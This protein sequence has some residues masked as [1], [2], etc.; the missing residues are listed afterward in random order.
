MTEVYA[1]PKRNGRA[2]A[3]DLTPTADEIFAGRPISGDRFARLDDVTAPIRALASDA[4]PEYV[5]SVLLAARESLA[6]ADPLTRQTVR[7]VALDALKGR[8]LGAMI[9]A[10][11]ARAPR[12]TTATARERYA[13]GSP[14]RLTEAGSAERFAEQH[15]DQVRFDHTRK[16]WLLWRGHRWAPDADAAIHRLALAFVRGWQREVLDLPGEKESAMKFLLRLERRDALA[17]MIGLAAS[18]KPLADDGRDW[19]ADPDLLGVPN[20]V[21]D[22]RSGELRDG[23]PEDRITMQAAVA[24]DPAATCPRWEQFVAEI[25]PDLD[26]ANFIH[27]AIGYALTG[28]TSEQI[29]LFLL[30]RGANGK[31]TLQDVL[32]RMLGDYGHAL[33][34]SV[35]EE[36]RAGSPSNELAALAGRRLVISSE[37]SEGRRL[38]AGRV[39]W[40]TGGDQIRAR[41][42]YLESFEFTPTFKFMLAANHRPVVADDS[43]GFW[44]RIRLIPFTKTFAVDPTLAPALA[45]E[46]PGILAWAVR[47]C[48]LWRSEGL[49]A[50]EAVLTATEA[51]RETS[52]MLGS[53][54]AEACE[55]GAGLS[56][57]AGDLYRQYGSWAASQ[58]IG[59]RERLSATAFGRRMGERFVASR[60]RSGKRYCGVGLVEAVTGFSSQMTGCEPNVQSPLSNSRVGDFTQTTRNPA[61]P[62]TAA[63]A[64]SDETF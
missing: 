30:G 31:G 25:L 22:L 53:F 4:T 48:L 54:L 43:P 2:E 12:T 37:T 60:S 5:E 9:D 35:L 38:D 26:T 24:F 21:V 7:R 13:A 20:G 58:G 55:T 29:L 36:T 42:L 56:V 18:L 3:D 45:A 64:A 63:P 61:Q 40:L 32:R 17:S 34:F 46:L 10:A 41:F 14:W 49:R 52:D 57:A 6:S 50:P 8:G 28:H 51:Y 15:G 27:R 19:D 11:F 59:E 62:N 33:A 39:K 1:F 47:G 44:R 16:R 23:R